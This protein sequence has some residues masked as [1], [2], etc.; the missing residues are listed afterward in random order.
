MFFCRATLFGYAFAEALRMNGNKIPRSHSAPAIRQKKDAAEPK[1][2]ASAEALRMNGNK[3]PRSHSAPA[4][5]QKKDAA[6]PKRSAS[7]RFDRLEKYSPPATKWPGYHCPLCLQNHYDKLDLTLGSK[8]CQPQCP[9]R[10]VCPQCLVNYVAHQK[11]DSAPGSTQHKCSCCRLQQQT[12]GAIQPDVQAA[13]VKLR[14][15]RRPQDLERREEPELEDDFDTVFEAVSRDGYNLR[16]ASDR[17]RHDLRIVLTA[18][19]TASWQGIGSPLIE[20]RNLDEESLIFV[21]EAVDSDNWTP[22][23]RLDLDDTA[24]D[25]FSGFGGLPPKSDDCNK[26][27]KSFG[28][29]STMVTR[30]AKRS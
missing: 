27:C 9:G 7:Q 8:D 20:H 13:I 10:E 26:S 22:R 24:Y 4:I 15:Q 29:T 21:R 11:I 16:F 17:L 1:R 3:I 28:K 30:M 18:L 19:K 5:R 23:R 12:P 25:F 2:S 14:G 6:E